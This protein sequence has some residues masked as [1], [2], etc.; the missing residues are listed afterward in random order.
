MSRLQLISHH[1]CPYVQ[2]A[3][4]TLSEKAIDH[5]RIYIDLADKPTWFQ[6]LSPLGRVPVLRIGAAVLFESAVICEYLDE[7]TPGWLHPQ[8]ALERA[9][10]RAWIEFASATLD[11]IAGFYNATEAD[12]FANRLATLHDRF[13]RLEDQLGTGPYFAGARFHLVDAA[14]APVFRYLDT[15]D[16]AGGFGL[17]DGL[18][19]VPAY[20]LAL[21]ER[22]SVRNAV[23]TDYPERLYD[24][25]L[26]RNSHL[27]GLLRGAA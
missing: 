5:E 12:A 10:H 9:R 18:V 7:S 2:R 11:G 4:I 19:R 21:A 14:W 6:T 3:V 22:A 27:A 15:F 1:L 8:D 13:G 26:H 16:A 20:R 17:L 24:F 25:L 23:T